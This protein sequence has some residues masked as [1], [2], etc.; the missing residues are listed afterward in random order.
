MAVFMRNTELSNTARCVLY[1]V[2]ASPWDK[3]SRAFAR[4]KRLVAEERPTMALHAENYSERLEERIGPYAPV[5]FPA[6][7]DNPEHWPTS[8]YKRGYGKWVG[9]EGAC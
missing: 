7:H 6:R 2:L 9:G 5:D 4:S 3:S 1:R 8:Q